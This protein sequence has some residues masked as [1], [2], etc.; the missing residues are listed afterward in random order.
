MGM[1]MKRGAFGAWQRVDL[2]EGDPVAPEG[3]LQ[4]TAR[5]LADGVLQRSPQHGFGWLPKN[6]QEVGA[7]MAHEQPVSPRRDQCA[8]R[9]DCAGNVDRLSLAER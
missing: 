2:P 7:C 3:A 1:H 9:L 5:R 4:D 8:V 6:F